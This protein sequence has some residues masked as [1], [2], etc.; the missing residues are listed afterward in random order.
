MVD[1]KDLRENPEKYRCGAVLKNVPV[2][3]EQILRFDEQQR[4]AQRE[5][6]RF[7]SEQNEASKQ[8]GK[9]KDASEKQAAITRVAELKAGVRESEER[10]K[11]AAAS[12]EPLLLQ[13]PQPPDSDVPVGKDASENVVLYRWGQPRKFEFKPR[14]HLELARELDIIDF[15]AGVRLA[16]SRSYFLK[17]AGAELHAAV[18]RLAFDLMVHE[19]G[20]TP[21]TVPVLVRE[22]A[23]RGTGF[24]PA[25]REQA[26]R[27][28]E[29]NETGDEVRFLTG[30]G[31]VGLTAYHMDE[32][33]EE[34]D[35]PRKYTTISTCFRRE[36]G[37][38]G[39]DTAGLYRV[40]QFDKCEQ[41]VI[42]R[43]DVE[44]SK[45][46][47]VEM[48]GYSEEVLKRL[49]LPYR[50]I[51]CCTG[52]IGVKNASMMDIETWM[53]SRLNEKD[54]DN[55]AYGETHSAS[56]L[57]EFQA[58]RLNLRYRGADGKIRYCHTLN[59]T[60]VASPRILIPILENYQNADGSVSVPEVLR[61]Y[62]NGRERIEKKK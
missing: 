33:L 4:A 62:M 51:Q 1:L 23:M 10:S 22:S 14:S 18:L 59:N 7:R 24:F 44:E 32:V 48:L 27:V 47:H 28:G 38:Y 45:R 53:P 29:P 55:S 26:Y 35:L 2:D 21:M 37:T 13:V 41:V 42:C 40:H 58:R 36:A 43:N 9:L 12:L 39:K 34:S 54:P 15:E 5:F 6:E 25:G 30:T 50:V 52:D 19:K 61:K 3:I 16:G 60:V 17:G 8:I 11:A 31:E 56:R 46:W 49:N 20:F 57:Y